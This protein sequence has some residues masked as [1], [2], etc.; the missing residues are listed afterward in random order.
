MADQKSIKAQETIVHAPFGSI[1]RRGRAPALPIT[2]LVQARVEAGE[3]L[4]SLWPPV[5]ASLS[6]GQVMYQRHCSACH[7]ADGKNPGLVGLKFQP[8]PM[9]LT[10]DYVRQ[11]PDGRLYYTVSRGSVVMPAYEYTMTPA[12]RWALVNYVRHGLGK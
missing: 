12:D 9:D 4:K 5:F 1:S 7:G 6:Q 11:Q 3:T 8:K 10:T 2:P